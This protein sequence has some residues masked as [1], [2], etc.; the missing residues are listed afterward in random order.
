VINHGVE[1]ALIAKAF[2]QSH[3]FFGPLADKQALAALRRE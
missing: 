1:A 3:R 2:M